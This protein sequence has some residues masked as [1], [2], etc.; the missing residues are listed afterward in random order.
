[1]PT[2]RASNSSALTIIAA[3]ASGYTAKADDLVKIT[4]DNEVN[5]AGADDKVIGVV[6]SVSASTGKLTVEV[7]ASALVTIRAAENISAGA[8]L[9]SAAVSSGIQRVAVCAADA[10]FPLH[11]GVCLKGANSGSDIE[12]L[13]F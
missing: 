3:A 11:L 5:L 10:N 2:L 13:I 9:K 4:G 1:M 7:F 12:A 8:F 6:R